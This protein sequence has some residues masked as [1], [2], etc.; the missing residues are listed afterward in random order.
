MEAISKEL[1]FVS[2]AV[3][4]AKTSALAGRGMAQTNSASAID[5]IET[6]KEKRRSRMGSR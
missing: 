1:L 4:A 2:V 6:G 3:P 5:Q